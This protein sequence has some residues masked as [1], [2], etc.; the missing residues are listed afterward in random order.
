MVETTNFTDK[1]PYRGSS[2]SLRMVE[3]FTPMSPEVVE[4]SV[5]FDD[6]QTWTRPWTFAMSLTK[7]DDSQRPYRVRVSRGKSRSR[8]I[9]RAGRADDKT[10]GDAAPSDN[11]PGLTSS[12]V[13]RG[14]PITL[15]SDT[16]LQ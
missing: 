3:R 16:L 11:E 14:T 13:V 15:H 7:K 4:W 1:T 5:T 10:A 9:L 2:E 8:R 6:S 12:K